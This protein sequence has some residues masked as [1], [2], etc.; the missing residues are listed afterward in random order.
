M[1][2]DDVSD[3]GLPETTQVQSVKIDN[4]LI[5]IVEVLPQKL[6]KQFTNICFHILAIS[7]IEPYKVSVS[8][9]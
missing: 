2:F 1:L 9:S 8:I 5:F 3:V 4:L 6:D 7:W